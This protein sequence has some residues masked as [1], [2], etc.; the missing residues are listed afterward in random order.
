VLDKAFSEARR[1]Q[2]VTLVGQDQ[3][4]RDGTTPVGGRSVEVPTG[5]RIVSQRTFDG[6]YPLTVTTF[7]QVPRRGS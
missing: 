5:W 2:F 3:L 6:I 1:V 7:E 4:K